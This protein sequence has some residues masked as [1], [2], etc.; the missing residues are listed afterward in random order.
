MKEAT[1]TT[2]T[3]VQKSPP[4]NSLVVQ[5]AMPIPESGTFDTQEAG[6]TG[7]AFREVLHRG[8]Y[9]HCRR[10]YP[11]SARAE[12]KESSP[13]LVF[14]A[15][16]IELRRGRS[17]LRQAVEQGEGD[18]ELELVRSFDIP[19]E[20]EEDD[21]TVAVERDTRTLQMQLLH[22]A[23]QAGRVR[24]MGPMDRYTGYTPAASNAMARE[25][26][27]RGDNS[28]ET[29]VCQAYSVVLLLV[30]DYIPY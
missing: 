15:S 25:Q 5:L 24:A 29:A 6:M 13:G 16:D 2:A 12:Q 17:V 4:L 11:Q 8:K 3:E 20:G 18:M 30:R 14:R 22:T 1:W 21:D 19:V 28:G 10:G 7:E 9:Q 23:T 26:E 27:Q